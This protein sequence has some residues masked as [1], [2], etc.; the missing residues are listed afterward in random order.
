M[1]GRVEQ[2][3]AALERADVRYLVVGGVAIVLHGSG[4]GEDEA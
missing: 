2:V 3:L 1:A 4:L